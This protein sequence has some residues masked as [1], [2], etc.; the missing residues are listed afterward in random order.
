MELLI[1]DI[2]SQEDMKLIT[3]LAKRLGLKTMK[4][5]AEEKEEIG[6]LAAIEK[7]RKSGYVDEDT[8]MQTLRAIQGKK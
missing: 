2:T 4:L 3:G 5:S 8:V 6:L 1:K 7:G